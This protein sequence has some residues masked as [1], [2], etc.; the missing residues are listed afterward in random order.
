M[1][2]DPTH[3]VPR[4]FVGRCN[5]C[6]PVVKERAFSISSGRA[7]QAPVAPVSSQSIPLKCS[8]ALTVLPL[9]RASSDSDVLSMSIPG[10]S[11]YLGDIARE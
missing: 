10:V 5:L 9:L 8:S 2:L 3:Q 1:L 11:K 6:N 7:E 4:A